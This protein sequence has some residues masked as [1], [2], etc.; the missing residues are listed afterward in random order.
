[1]S[2]INPKLASA[3]GLTLEGET[4]LQVVVDNIAIL[5]K[6]KPTQFENWQEA[7]KYCRKHIIPKKVG[8]I[9]D[10]PE[11]IVYSTPAS[12]IGNTLWLCQ[13]YER[14]DLKDYRKFEY[15]FVRATRYLYTTGDGVWRKDEDHPK[16]NH[17]D[18]TYAGLPK[19]LRQIF[20]AHESEILEALITP[21]REA[22]R[23]EYHL[24]P[25][26]GAPQYTFYAGNEIQLH[27]F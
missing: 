6:S 12:R 17:N 5:F 15:G 27:L 7:L 2:S 22:D 24:V 23:T 19:G 14:W 20:L 25:G 4:G 8:P 11:G 13:V 18:G 10:L 3:Y 9:V 16:Y 26:Q 1:M 21:D